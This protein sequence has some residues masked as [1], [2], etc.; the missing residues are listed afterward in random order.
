MTPFRRLVALHGQLT[1]FLGHLAKLRPAAEVVNG[2]RAHC[3]LFIVQHFPSSCVSAH[4]AISTASARPSFTPPRGP[5]N[6]T[7]G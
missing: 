1:Q 4:F 6:G 2:S 5:A 7:W 3:L